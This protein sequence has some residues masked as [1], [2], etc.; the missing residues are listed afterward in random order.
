MIDKKNLKP[1]D[2]I[3]SPKELDNKI[4]LESAA[5]ID[6]QHVRYTP[7]KSGMVGY[8]AGIATII[9]ILQFT[10]VGHQSITPGDIDISPLKVNLRNSSSNN[11]DLSIEDLSYTDLVFLAEHFARKEDWQQLRKLTHYIEKRFP[12]KVNKDS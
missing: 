9:F 8:V 5:K 10:T 3:E 12:A 4:L 7:F 6:R 11:E 2:K 1:L